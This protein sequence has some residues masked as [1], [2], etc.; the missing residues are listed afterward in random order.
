MG[1]PKFIQ[2]SSTHYTSMDGCGLT[3]L[4]NDGAEGYGIY[5]MLM[6]ALSGTEARMLSM[7]V[8]PQLAYQFRN[9]PDKVMSI[10]NSYMIVEDNCFYCDELDTIL[11]PYD[12]AVKGG[13][14]RA[15]SLTTEERKSIA[16]KGG[17][18]KASNAAKKLQEYKIPKEKEIIP[19]K[20]EK[21]IIPDKDED[22]KRE[23]EIRVDI[24]KN[25]LDGSKNIASI[26]QVDSKQKPTHS[27]GKQ[28]ESNVPDG[29]INTDVRKHL[30]E[31]I[32][33]KEICINDETTR[34]NVIDAMKLTNNELCYSND[35]R[36]NWIRTFIR[37]ESNVEDDG[38]VL[39]LRNNYIPAVTDDN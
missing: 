7:S 11:K 24:D 22:K 39:L 23:E 13:N 28:V 6:E 26:E 19:D 4:L 10:I 32:Q 17:K 35:K 29:Y 33:L 15:A 37:N 27:V 18:A 16:S 12:D 21:E 14:A 5:V 30:I 31:C 25:R 1:K 9:T 38:L 34:K 20:D 8:I 3:I 36:F 2:L